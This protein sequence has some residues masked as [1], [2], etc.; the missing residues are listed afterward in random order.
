MAW[1]SV[2]L[3]LLPVRDDAW[4]R[5]DPDA[6][7]R[8]AHLRLWA[9]LVRRSCPAYRPAPASLLAFTAWQSGDGAL[10][11]IALDLALEA[12]PG[13]S[14]ALL[15]RDIMEAGVPPS[16]A[17]LPMTPEQ[18]AAGYAAAGY[19]AAPAV[20]STRSQMPPRPR[21]RVRPGGRRG[22]DGARGGSAGPPAS[23]GPPGRRN[24][25]PRGRRAG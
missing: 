8:E 10:A 9:D 14:L 5:M 24:G 12:D 15:L 11:N 7:L 18:V 2:V 19:E 3:A 13:Y 23:D 17:R 21:E 6:A 4:A 16:A 1:L 22:A 25:I 20:A